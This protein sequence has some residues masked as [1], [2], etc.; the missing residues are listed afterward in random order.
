MILD[1]DMGQENQ[2][3]LNDETWHDEQDLFAHDNLDH[4]N[5]VKLYAADGLD[6]VHQPF[7]D[8]LH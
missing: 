5:I 3:N 2:V 7:V 6:V 4:R 1:D 8:I